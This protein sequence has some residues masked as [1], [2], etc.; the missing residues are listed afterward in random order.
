[1]VLFRRKNYIQ[2]ER[3]KIF[4]EVTEKPSE[5]QRSRRHKTGNSVTLIIGKIFPQN[6]TLPAPKPL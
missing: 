4:H 1:M 6:I 5:P 3:K 2:K